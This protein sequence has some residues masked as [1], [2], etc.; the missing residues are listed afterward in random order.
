VSIGN[1][2][3]WLVEAG[4]VFDLDG[5]ETGG[6][7]GPAG[8]RSTLIL[9]PCDKFSA[10]ER[11]ESGSRSV[12]HHL[13]GFGGWGPS[14]AFGPG[15]PGRCRPLR[16]SDPTEARPWPVR[17]AQLGRFSISG[18]FPGSVESLATGLQSPQGGHRQAGSVAPLRGPCQWLRL[19]PLSPCA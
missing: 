6:M 8:S 4:G 5:L 3:P 9:A 11:G 10:G 15:D 19:L 1:I 16:G 17:L 2:G 12:A 14:G 18:E 13:R 7:L